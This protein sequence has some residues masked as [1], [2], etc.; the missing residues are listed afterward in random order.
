MNPFKCGCG[1]LVGYPDCLDPVCDWTCT[2]PGQLM[3]A[4]CGRFIRDGGIVHGDDVYCSSRCM[5]GD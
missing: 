2:E 1:E 4:M 3:C 5:H